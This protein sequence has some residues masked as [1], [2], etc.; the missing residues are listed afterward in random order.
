MSLFENTATDQVEQIDPQKDYLAELV[1]EG[2]KFADTQALARGK[3]EADA[4]I[5]RM[6][7]E[8]A[9]LRTELERRK[10]MED[11]VKQLSEVNAQQRE[12]E[13]PPPV[14]PVSPTNQPPVDI[15]AEI[16]KVFEQRTQAE[17]ENANLELVAKVLEE[18]LGPGFAQVAVQKAREIGV[19]PQFLDNLSRTQPKA[20]FKLLDIPEQVTQTRA[21]VQTL[22]SAPSN[23]E[24]KNFAYYDKLR[25]EKP[26]V[27]NSLAIHKEMMANLEA[28]GPEAFYG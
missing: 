4:M 20:V 10:A 25:K 5:K 12:V 17:R 8:Q 2:K 27:Y 7:A 1:G 13:T 11:L 24:V 23:G 21:P 18:R 15:Q 14:A 26:Q 19:G 28:L 3:A 22:R 16:R 9:A 6:I